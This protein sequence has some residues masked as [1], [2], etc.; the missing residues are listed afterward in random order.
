MLELKLWN[1]YTNIISQSGFFMNWYVC[2]WADEERMIFFFFMQYFCVQQLIK[3]HIFYN[4]VC[5]QCIFWIIL[6]LFN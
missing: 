2:A 5:M 6:Q 1:F 3:L 4:N